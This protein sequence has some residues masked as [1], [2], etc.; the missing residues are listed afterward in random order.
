MSKVTYIFVIALLGFGYGG[1]VKVNEEK[2]DTAGASF[3]EP[4]GK[5]WTV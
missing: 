1:E 2:L 5:E 3:K 4:L